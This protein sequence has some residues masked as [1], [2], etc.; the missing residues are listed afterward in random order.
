MEEHVAGPEPEYFGWLSTEL[1]LHVFSYLHHNELVAISAACKTLQAIGDSEELWKPLYCQRYRILRFTL[2]G[3]KRVKIDWRLRFK[4][5]WMEEQRITQAI[6]GFRRVALEAYPSLSLRAPITIREVE[7]W[8]QKNTVVLPE[9]YKCFITEV[10]N[11]GPRRGEDGALYLVELP[12]SLEESYRT[13]WAPEAKKDW[14][15]KLGGESLYVE[16]AVLLFVGGAERG[17]VWDINKKEMVANSYLDYVLERARVVLAQAA[18][19][20][21][22]VSRFDGLLDFLGQKPETS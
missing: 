21:S 22:H 18:F 8:E 11:G 16:S 9:D 15:K 5:R 12:P 17:H 6:E 3:F 20:W 10:G 4:N 14:E 2:D 1:L 13:F 7:K 19:R